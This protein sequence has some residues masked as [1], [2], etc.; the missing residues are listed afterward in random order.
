MNNKFEFVI[1]LV[2]IVSLVTLTA[3]ERIDNELFSS[4]FSLIIGYI[5]KG[6]VEK[7]KG[8]VNNCK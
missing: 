1:I 4:L 7:V 8:G 2:L 3:I 5:I 6:R